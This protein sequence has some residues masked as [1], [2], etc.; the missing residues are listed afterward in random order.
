MTIMSAKFQM[1]SRWQTSQRILACLTRPWAFYDSMIFNGF[2][3]KECLFMFEETKGSCLVPR[4][5]MFIHCTRLLKFKSTDR[6]VMRID[7]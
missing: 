3:R 2:L 7:L 6:A 1:W 4:E 5:S